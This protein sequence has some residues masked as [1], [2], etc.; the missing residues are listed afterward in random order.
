VQPATLKV[1]GPQAPYFGASDEFS[2]RAHGYA[3]THLD[4][5][6]HC[7]YDGHFWNGKPLNEA[8]TEDGVQFG[9]IYVQ[10]EGIVTRG[11]LL[12]VARA[13]GVPHLERYD[14]VTI[15]DLDAAEKLSGTR[16]TTGDA[17]FVRAGMGL[18]ISTS[19]DIATR[20]GLGPECARW[21][22]QRE[23][24][25]FGSDCPEKVPSGYD[26]SLRIAFHQ[27]VLVQ[28][29]LILLDNVAMEP[30]ARACQEE[31]STDFMFTVAPLRI[32]KATGSVV[33]PL[34]I[35]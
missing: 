31:G 25:V 1:F 35:F 16:V 4:A 20:T 22:H 19:E 8:V 33:N 27:L 28:M 9:S 32:P 5:L 29:G 23:V 6:T 15:D 2:I 7:S 26:A 14:T 24:S 10:R 17:V 18:R 30:L 12:D 13:R 11:V 21:L 3:P 34:A